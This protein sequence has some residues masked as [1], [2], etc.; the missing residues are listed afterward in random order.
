MPI[1]YVC[2]S[3]PVYS[4]LGLSFKLHGDA[5]ESQRTFHL[6]EHGILFNRRL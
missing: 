4:R 3:S 6:E 2:Q 5:P 1:D